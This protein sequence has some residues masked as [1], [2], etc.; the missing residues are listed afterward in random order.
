MVYPCLS[1]NCPLEIATLWGVS[2]IF[3]HPTLCI[4]PESSFA[5]GILH[6]SWLF[7]Y[8]AHFD[9]VDNVKEK[10]A[11]KEETMLAF[12]RSSR[13]LKGRKPLLHPEVL[14][15]SIKHGNW[16]SPLLPIGLITKKSLQCPQPAETQPPL[17]WRD[18]RCR[19]WRPV[20]S[21]T[22]DMINE[23]FLAGPNKNEVMMVLSIGLVTL[24]PHSPMLTY[25][26]ILDGQDPAPVC[27]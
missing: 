19:S 8:D 22:R 27:N 25:W 23:G 13:L 20:P 3:S 2:P 12:H 1:S 16:K 5:T 6:I 9:K 18:G 15:P 17:H 14:K 26:D 24:S 11:H 21:V 7:L 10:R 4:N